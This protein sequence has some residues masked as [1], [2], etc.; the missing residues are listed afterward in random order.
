MGNEH[1]ARKITKSY[2]AEAR[3]Q[4]HF[5]LKQRSGKTT[6]ILLRGSITTDESDKQN[7]RPIQEEAHGSRKQ[8]EH[9][10]L[11]TNSALTRC[12]QKK[13]QNGLGDEDFVRFCGQPARS[14]QRARGIKDQKEIPTKQKTRQEITNHEVYH[15]V[16]Y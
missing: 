12:E 7:Q 4:P 2:R 16:Y 9:P 5:L 14:P 11:G 6:N 8:R 10:H 1:T 15:S 3:S 13:P